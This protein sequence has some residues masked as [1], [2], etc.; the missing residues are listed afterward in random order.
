MKHALNKLLSVMLS[1]CLL[2]TLALP[3]L[4]A[5]DD[6]PNV[7]VN[8][9]VYKTDDY[10][11]ADSTFIFDPATGTLTIND[12]GNAVPVNDEYAFYEWIKSI[13]P[14]V[15]T[16]FIPKTG[17]LNNFSIGEATEEDVEFWGE[18]YQNVYASNV[19][20]KAF[21]Y[22][23][24]LER[25]EVEKGNRFFESIDGVLYAR[26]GYYLVHYPA[27]KPDKTY[28]IDK[29]CLLGIYPYAFCNTRYLERLELPYARCGN[30]NY[31]MIEEYA[32]SALDLDDG[33]EQ[34]G[35]IR[36]ISFYGTKEEFGKVTSL[37]E[38]NNAARQAEIVS[39]ETDF[40]H[41][42]ITYIKV[43]YFVYFRTIL[44]WLPYQRPVK[45]DLFPYNMLAD[46]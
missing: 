21:S 20:W 32:L 14:G 30:L 23:Q 44:D 41:D 39:K 9:G 43:N 12:N 4:A 29:W 28:Q 26:H 27:A 3:A 8:K 13:A 17:E 10:A 1:A 34:Q 25:F 22:L 19:F 45:T 40:V 35:S 31:L 18:D 36:E 38:G 15:K 33:T 16:V 11:D 42:I 24:N 37:Y 46:D 2:L 7:Y 6:D 5:G